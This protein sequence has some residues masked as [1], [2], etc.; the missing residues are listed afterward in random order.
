MRRGITR[1][2]GLFL[3]ALVAATPR[4][5]GAQEHEGEHREEEPAGRHLEYVA[6]H[7]GFPTFVDLFST[8]HAYLER[9]VNLQVEA[10]A[11]DDEN[12]FEEFGE[13]TWQFNRWFGAEIEVPFAQIDPDEGEGAGGLGD[14]EIGPQI[15]LLQ[16]VD[17]LLIIGARSGFVIPTGDEDDGIGAD[18]WT[19]E[20]GFLVWKGFGPHSRG[21]VQAELTYER[22]FPDDDGLD[23]EEQV[24][25]NVGLSYWTPSNFIPI[26]ELTGSTRISDE[27]EDEAEGGGGLVPA[28]GGS[29]GED[30]TLASLLLG[31]RY[32]F[33]GGQQW[34][35]GVQFPLTGTESFDVR[36]VVGGVIHL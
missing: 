16:S 2:T 1:S 6:H 14:I 24:V 27:E 19:W 8:H 25:Y 36:L 3:A 7:G 18:G 35:A 20:P 26:V 31:F 21:A 17:D 22:F 15:A 4:V 23:D 32:G 12:E 11:A 30:D 9:K 5:V 33:A 10:T 13:L 29:E 28:S 34:G